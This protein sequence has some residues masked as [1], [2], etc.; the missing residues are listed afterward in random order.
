MN[1][2]IKS[3]RI[4]IPFIISILLILSFFFIDLKWW[5]PQ[6]KINL[7]N[8]GITILFIIFFEFFAIIF[9]NFYQK[10]SIEKLRNHF[11]ISALIK[12]NYTVLLFNFPLV[13]IF[14][15]LLF[16]LF[17]FT[18]LYNIFGYIS[19]GIVS[20]LI[21]GIYHIHIWFEFKDKKITFS[22]ITISISLGLILS[23]C[24]VFFGIITCIFIHY[25]VV[26]FLFYYIK[27][28]IKKST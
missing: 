7:I 8:C 26:L 27:T 23:A 12:K 1:S 3:K 17:I 10:D 28:L 9:I 18:F 19:A 11:M 2:Y 24:L 15:E 13:I 4:L 6:G 22:F 16:R 5:F 20:T 14:E 25:F 21:F